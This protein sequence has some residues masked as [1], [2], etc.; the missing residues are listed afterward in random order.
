M[1]TQEIQLLARED[2]LPVTADPKAVLRRSAWRGAAAA[3]LPAAMLLL[4]TP[5]LADAL[6]PFLISSLHS[7]LPFA[8]SF[9]ISMTVVTLWPA[10]LALPVAVT[11]AAAARAQG[12]RDRERGLAAAAGSSIAT[13]ALTAGYVGWSL[14]TSLELAMWAPLA[15][16]SALAVGVV[17][18]VAFLSVPRR[19]G[20]K[21]RVP[22][23]YQGLLAAGLG[24]PSLVVGGGA[25]SLLTWFL[26]FLSAAAIHS[27]LPTTVAMTVYPIL[28]LSALAPVT[29][30]MARAAKRSFPDL[31]KGAVGAGLLFPPLL[32]FLILSASVATRMSASATLL[33][34]IAGNALGV[35]PHLLAVV[36][37]LRDDTRRPA[38]LGPGRGAALPAGDELSDTG[39]PAS[40]A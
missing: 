2:D 38:R 35:L 29:Y 33:A 16:A 20:E 3:G 22:A 1:E 25:W 34:M 19:R 32:P 39:V 24:V 6:L 15:A 7:I 40:A 37:G 12:R 31:S 30:G 18:G 4:S 8:A 21:M 28:F 5:Y 17:G 10:V 23:L 26:P 14:L 36:A 9:Y 11:A 27:V 13:A